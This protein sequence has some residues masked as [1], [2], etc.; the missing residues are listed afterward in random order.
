MKAVFLVGTFDDVART[1][2]SPL[3]PNNIELLKRI[4]ADNGLDVTVVFATTLEMLQSMLPSGFARRCDADDLIP[5][6]IGAMVGC[7]IGILFRVHGE[8][9][10]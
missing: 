6:V 4:G 1:T 3:S 7:V 5:S 8:R 9:P 10:C 2:G